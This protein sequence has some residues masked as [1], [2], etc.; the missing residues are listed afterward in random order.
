[1]SF[2]GYVTK[3]GL[4]VVPTQSILTAFTTSVATRRWSTL[5]REQRGLSNVRILKISR[6]NNL[7]EQFM[8]SET[9]WPY[10]SL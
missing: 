7:Y 10:T 8:T 1:M 2:I 3:M 4:Q 6:E 5:C 9:A